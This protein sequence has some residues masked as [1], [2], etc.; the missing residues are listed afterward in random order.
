SDYALLVTEPTPFGLHDL[1]IAVGL[2]KKM[3]IRSGVI[4]N[5][6]GANDQIIYD[7]CN[8]EDLPV[9]MEIPFSRVIA[10][11]YAR[12]ILP[13]SVGPGW[14]I[15]NSSVQWRGGQEVMS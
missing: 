1:K 6:A 13:T 9:L 10:E 2:V 11:H 14:K 7:Y 3:G 5:K 8:Q 4:L 15:R 12:C